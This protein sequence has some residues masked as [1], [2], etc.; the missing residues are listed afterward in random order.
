MFALGIEFLT[1]TAVM[2]AA[3]NRETA[4]WP[5][6]PARVFM[7]F[8]AAH[9]ETK[10]L[11]EDS[12]DVKVRWE[13]ERKCLEWLERQ[14]APKL[15][16]TE[17]APKHRR[18]VVKFYVPVNDTALHEKSDKVTP[19]NLFLFR[20]KQDRTFPAISLGFYNQRNR[21]YLVWPQGELPA[22]WR[23]AF[24]QLAAKVI[25]I[26]HSSSLVAVWLADN[27]K[28][29]SPSDSF[30]LEPSDNFGGVKLRIATKGLLSDL[31]RWFN[32]EE[33]EAF[34]NLGEQIR[35]ATGKT[36]TKAKEE[37]EK[38]FGKNWTPSFPVPVQRRPNIG[39]T[40]AYVSPQAVESPPG[41]SAFDSDILVLTKFDGRVLGLESTNL[42]VEALRGTLLSGSED[43][44]EWFTGHREDGKPFDAMH[45]ALFPLAY[46]GGEYADGHILGLALAFPRAIP[47]KDRAKPLR[48]IL[49]DDSGEERKITLKLGNQ[50][51]WVLCR[52]ERSFRPVALSTETWTKPSTIWASVTPVV[53][54]RHPKLNPA[55]PEEREAWRR[56][57]ADIVCTSCEHIG[58]PKPI[59]VDIDK[60][61]WHRGALRSRPGP[62]GM[63]WLAGNAG[64]YRQQVH[65]YL[66]FDQ[67]IEGPILLGAGRYRGY[68]VCKPLEIPLF[69]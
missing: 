27:E 6:H 63:P 38:H 22:E 9:Y 46:V 54:D 31:D 14:P 55:K 8:V 28:E 4:E 21:V 7:A 1:G 26:G 33:I 41:Q 5:P 66:R 59:A 45:L 58:L 56:E 61:S 15:S 16:F 69:S 37:F 12:E 68:G 3:N 49:F 20:S 24:E 25:R 32:A 2:T 35:S 34:F 39:I 40:Q 44:P 52:E 64:S 18:S 36:K 53:L 60:T 50:G 10:P 51:T 62:N 48:R 43:A 11:S 17:V 13:A 42:L 30:T 19:S 57:V 65:V 29:I 67:E 47:E 23:P